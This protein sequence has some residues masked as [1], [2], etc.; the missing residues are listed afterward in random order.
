MSDAI[1][2]PPASFRDSAES[3]RTCSTVRNNAGP[4]TSCAA[5]TAGYL[6]SLWSYSICWLEVLRQLW[7]KTPMPVMRHEKSWK[8]LLPQL[9]Q[10]T[11][12]LETRVLL[13]RYSV[14]SNLSPSCVFRTRAEALFFPYLLLLS[15]QLLAED[16]MS[17]VRAEVFPYLR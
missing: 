6:R 12:T 4:A 11:K 16:V 1:A 10:S 8:E 9:R 7:H 2:R 14:S 5:S 15:R 3:A 17:A 13:A